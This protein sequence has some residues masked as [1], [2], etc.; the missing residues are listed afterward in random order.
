MFTLPLGIS[1]QCTGPLSFTILGSTSGQ[2]LGLRG[3][4]VLQSV[5]NCGLSDASVMVSINGGSAPY[6]YNIS[7]NPSPC[8]N[9][10]LGYTG[11]TATISS[12]QHTFSNLGPGSYYFCVTDF[13]GCSVNGAMVII[14]GQPLRVNTTVAI[15]TLCGQTLGRATVFVSNQSAAPTYLWSNGSTMQTATGL[16]AGVYNVTV[17]AGAGCSLTSSV[18]IGSSDGPLISSPTITNATCPN[19]NGSAAL[20]ITGGTAPYTYQWSGV[21]SGTNPRNNLAAGNFSVT[22]TD[23]AGCRSS[24]V[25][26]V[27][28][29]SNVT[30]TASTIDATCG[31]A[32]GSATMAASGGSAPYIFRWSN[33]QTA[34]GASSSLTGLAAGTY[35]ATITDANG[36]TGVAAAVVDNVAGTGSL[37]VGPISNVTCPGGRN[38]SFTASVTGGGYV[39]VTS[40]SG[41]N[42]T[43]SNLSAG[44]YWVTGYTNA[45]C[46]VGS[47][48]VTI[49][50]PRQ[51]DVVVNYRPANCLGTQQNQANISFSGGQTP[52]S[53]LWSDGSTLTSRTNFTPGNYQITVTNGVGCSNSISFNALGL[54]CPPPVYT[55]VCGIVNPTQQIRV[56]ATSP[57]GFQNETFNIMSGPS[58]LGINGQ[59][60][61]FVPVPGQPGCYNYT[62][63]NLSPNLG[64]V[65]G[66]TDVVR[67]RVCNPALPTVCDTFDFRIFVNDPPRIF[68]PGR[69]ATDG[70]WEDTRSIVPGQ[71]LT[72]CMFATNIDNIPCIGQRRDSV[73]TPFIHGPALPG[74]TANAIFDN[75]AGTVVP[76]S[77]PPYSNGNHYCIV[78]NSPNIPGGRDTILFRACDPLGLCD[79]M[80]LIVVLY[81]FPDIIDL[82]TSNPYRNDTAFVTVQ[83]GST[84]NWCMT[85]DPRFQSETR[86]IA[87]NP[88]LPGASL[89]L[90]VDTCMTYV[91][92]NSPGATDQF[93]IIL[94]NPNA[95][96]MC[97][98]MVVMVNI[99]CNS[100]LLG[101][102][103]NNATTCASGGSACIPISVAS[104][105]AASASILVDGFTYTGA[106][107]SCNGGNGTSIALSPGAHTI[108][109]SYGASCVTNT[110]SGNITAPSSP[111]ITNVS[112][113]NVTQCGLNNGTISIT[114]GVAGTPPYTITQSGQPLAPPATISQL[115]NMLTISGLGVGSYSNFVLTDAAGCTA[116]SPTSVSITGP[117]S[118]QIAS[119]QFNN[120]TTCNSAAYNG[121]IVVNLD[122]AQLGNPP[123]T[124]TFNGNPTTLTGGGAQ[125]TLPNLGPGAYGNLSIRLR[126]AS[127]CESIF[128]ANGS[129][130]TPPA[131]VVDNISTQNPTC[132]SN[133]GSIT[134]NMV[135]AVSN[136]T[137]QWSPNVGSPNANG[138]G[139]TNL[140]PGT[141]QITVT[142]N[143]T[144]CT[145][146]TSANIGNI[147]GPMVSV[148]STLPAVCT[149]SNGSVEINIS[150]VA[151]FTITWPGGGP[152]TLAASG[153]FTVPNLPAGSV[154]INVSDANNCLT[155]FQATVPLSSGN[156]SASLAVTTLPNCGGGTNGVIG[157]NVT[158]GQ[159]PFTATISPAVSA[160]LT[161]SSNNASF[162]NISAGTFNICVTD[163]NG[164][165]VCHTIQVNEAGTPSINLNDFTITNPTC[166][167]LVNGS[168]LE[169]PPLSGRIYEVYQNGVLIGNLPNNT[170]PPGN[171]YYLQTPFGAC[172]SV[173]P[174]FSITSPTALNA[175][176]TVSN[177]SCPRNNGQITLNVSGGTA[178]YNYSWSNGNSSSTASGLPTGNYFVTV[179]D[180]NGCSVSLGPIFVDYFCICNTFS[181]SSSQVTHTT[182]GENNGSISI[183]VSG[184]VQPYHYTW[185]D[186]PGLNQSSRSNL[187]P[188]TYSVTVTS[189]V[190]CTLTQTFNVTATPAFQVDLN[191]FT[192]TNITCPGLNDGAIIYSGPPTTTVYELY[193]GGQLVGNI[194][195]T[196]LPAGLYTVQATE[197]GCTDDAGPI[198]I[199]IPTVWDVRWVVVNELCGNAN[200]S[201]GVSVSGANGGYVFNWSNG[202]TSANLQGLSAGQYQLT[203]TDASGCSFT[204]GVLAVANPCGCD[205]AIDNA[206]VRNSGCGQTNGSISLS[207]SGG[208]NYSF[209]WSNGATTQNL[210]NIGMGLYTVT[211]VDAHCTVTQSIL[212]STQAAFTAS[213]SN[214]VNAVCGATNGRA[215]INVS[216]SGSYQVIWIDSNGQTLPTS[217]NGTSLNLANLP[218]GDYLAGVT[219]AG[220]SSLVSFTI[221]STPG[222]L[223]IS[224]AATIRPSC[225]QSNGR[226]TATLNNGVPNYRYTINGLPLG[227]LTSNR[228]ITANNLSAGIYLI[229]GTDGNGCTICDTISLDD[230]GTTPITP[231]DLTVTGNTCPG[232]NNGSISTSLVGGT[233]TLHSFPY[234][235]GQML[236]NL[237]QNSL[238]TGTYVVQA[239]DNGGCLSFATVVVPG[240]ASWSIS[241]SINDVHCL[242]ANGSVSLSVSGAN[243]PYGYLW[244]NGNTTSSITGIAN[245]GF[246][247]VTITDGLGCTTSLVGL[248]IEQHCGCTLA[249]TNIV[250]TTPLCGQANGN[251][252]VQ[253]TGGIG[254]VNFIWNDAQLPNAPSLTGLAA[255]VFSVTATDDFGCM[256][257]SGYIILPNIADG[258]VL[259]LVT[260]ASCTSTGSILVRANSGAAPF[261]TSLVGVDTVILSDLGDIYTFSNLNAGTYALL[262][263]DSAGCVAGQVLTVDEES[264]GFV[265]TANPVTLP[266]CN[267]DSSEVELVFGGSVTEATVSVNG[268]T[269]GLLTSGDTIR[270][271]RAG[272]Y[273]IDAVSP[274]GCTASDTLILDWA[275][276]VDVD[277]LITSVDVTCNGGRDGAVNQVRAFAEPLYL[278][279]MANNNLGQLPV[280]GLASGCYIVMGGAASCVNPVLV[281]IA[282]PDAWRL[283]ASITADGCFGDSIG[284]IQTSLVGG[285]SSGMA[286]LWSN[287][288]TMT[289]L[290]GLVSGNYGL[291][292]TSLGGCSQVLNFLVGTECDLL[293]DTVYINVPVGQSAS[294]CPIIA[295]GGVI[296]SVTNLQCSPIGNG[297]FTNNNSACITY[298]GTQVGQDTIC[299]EVCDDFGGCVVVL[300]IVNVTMSGGVP[301]VAVSDTVFLAGSDRVNVLV[302]SNDTLNGLLDTIYVVVGPRFGVTQVLSNGTI[303]YLNP[304][305]S[306]GVDSFVYAICNNFGCD[307]A[308]VVVN[309]ACEKVMVFNAISPD[310]NGEND[311]FV[312]EG[313][314]LYPENEVFI[315]NRWGNLVYKKKAY[316]NDWRGTFDG[317]PLPDGTYFYVIE[318][319]DSANSLPISG[320]LEIVR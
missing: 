169:N 156:L 223:S 282:E 68:L 25:V 276:G 138:N 137:Y 74:A 246:H 204:T 294:A 44:N 307:T 50:E 67:V 316:G 215:T 33:G 317:S 196:N 73:V 110:V 72:L 192:F 175:G 19:A 57:N 83:P 26:L 320:Y 292:V 281:C 227:N 236:G 1:A 164:C 202:A 17:N 15:N 93:T 122:P 38:G 199:T 258:G 54:N 81:D 60:G 131:P 103:F 305:D 280:S 195:Q 66:R 180:R 46:L 130:S 263:R 308:T 243:S 148:S 43:T 70:M 49:T 319:N 267:S 161:F 39:L 272:V 274:Q 163:A 143:A 162:N 97:D 253:T 158:G 181:V 186:N 302:L 290:T 22:V 273:R 198:S 27:S 128:A 124:F 53:V 109:I 8:G 59:P 99:A 185:S 101:V 56:C 229:C 136:F 179:T 48:M 167:G 58:L 218:A 297:T 92:P 75:Q 289:S 193:N 239:R 165:Q 240:P 278:Y 245:S 168:V 252:S 9:P 249:L 224:L 159:A 244:S 36:C 127:G 102:T 189:D 12:T 135:G 106:L 314:E 250:T 265:V 35:R 121:S 285:L 177:E 63:P 247:S 255:G 153:N 37:V 232:Q 225:G 296:T 260:N 194:P 154:T 16:A 271:L 5:S 261:E 212:V 29:N 262:Y 82:T 4:Q 251:I 287:G 90:G 118:P 157:L 45:G 132:G 111:T 254:N 142:S 71:S 80:R 170:L 14:G 184:A 264:D 213:V 200:G 203:I 201:I 119:V 174:L 133:N 40:L 129:I 313:I 310:G 295:L 269:Y 123:Y 88:I 188:G 217:I 176:F 77:Q 309:V 216:P 171:N 34:T 18:A 190:V 89:T 237:P 205:L 219:S 24:Q 306:C 155:N 76:P 6:T 139:R 113:T 55:D 299:L 283:Q 147:A 32:N 242:D 187:A 311:T 7:S 31:Q 96:T 241:S 98:T 146:T 107:N 61:S 117:N 21:G 166:N 268:S 235:S 211:V 13:Y 230:I 293:G 221:G 30:A 160:P 206:I 125:F 149:A 220:C 233:Y 3:S 10:L 28:Q 145:M 115:G 210:N 312:V 87:A 42:H 248:E 197:G 284:M 94:C 134:L 152:S 95:P 84:N 108:R 79:T 86:R 191:N 288:S 64:T 300:Y 209:T 231:V 112:S 23:A 315:Y 65:A 52:Y 116:S 270:G 140:P 318:L 303:V 208:T 183:Q 114:L 256:V 172:F 41:S 228:V 238:S 100:T 178:P 226:I 141:Y 275:N 266:N 259:S 78:Y 277:S 298:N 257:E 120:S 69:Q 20:T 207:V 222:L 173:S 291:T 47:Q 304:N 234:T 214:V 151:P 85:L 301:P 279:D 182:C 286:Y 150:G 11:A 105:N 51:F 126:D 91:A 104:L 62:A 2:P 144:A